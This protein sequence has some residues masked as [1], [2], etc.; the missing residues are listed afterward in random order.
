VLQTPLALSGFNPRSPCG[1]RHVK[2][3]QLPAF[4]VVSIHAPRVGSDVSTAIRDWSISCFN[5]RSPCGE[6]HERHVHKGRKAPGFN[7]RSPCGERLQQRRHS[8]DLSCCFNPRSPC[9]ERRFLRSGWS[10]FG[11][12]NPRS[13][14]GERPFGAGDA[15]GYRDV[16]IHAPRVGSDL[17]AFLQPLHCSKVSIH[18][19]RVGS[20]PRIIRIQRP[21]PV[22]QSTLPVWGATRQR[23]TQFFPSSVSI[24]APRVGSDSVLLDDKFWAATFQSTLPVWG[25]T[26]LIRQVPFQSGRFNP[27]S[28]CGERPRRA[29]CQP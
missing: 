7:P 8:L 28:P 2:A 3:N 13:P 27:R 1:E 12:F 25:A 17:Q 4:L 9:G 16:S 10:V 15:W 20:D 22:F 6:R 19:P 23:D 14:C 11:C 18:A 5:P 24:H 29:Q 26:H 21:I